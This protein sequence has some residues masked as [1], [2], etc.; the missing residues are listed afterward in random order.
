MTQ[1]IHSHINRKPSARLNSYS[2]LKQTATTPCAIPYDY[3][4]IRRLVRLPFPP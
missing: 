2:S 4:R 3:A 1:P